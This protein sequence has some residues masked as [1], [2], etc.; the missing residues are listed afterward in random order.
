M[1]SIII[2]AHNEATVISR[3]LEALLK[4]AAPEDEIIVC[5]NGCTDQTAEIISG[6]QPRVT[7]VCTSVP[8][9]VQA[10]NL[11]DGVAHSFPRI[12][13]DAD[14]VFQEGCL[15][16]LKQVLHSQNFLAVAPTPQMDMSDSS[17]AVRA[18]YRI[19]LS[20]PYC[21][22]GMIGAGVYG[23]SARGR[24]RFDRFPD[25]IADDGYVRALF[26]EHERCKV[27]GARVTVR[28]PAT[29]SSLL[30]IKIRSRT[31]QMQLASAYPDLLANERK[32][33]I[34]GLGKVMRNPARWPAAL[35]YLWISVATR[36]AAKNQLGRAATLTWEKDWS[37][38]R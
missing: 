2:P 34:G 12:Y 4:Q 11:G 30:R 6:Y 32:A 16:R 24:A 8:S 28:A 26:Q 29:L 15:D 27:D 10:L 33:Y 20:L 21:Q 5:A 22:R 25:L 3:S 37:S 36:V 17:W 38:R 1:A 14:V 31:G 19:W 9:K 23:L 35:V 18:Y 13:A 7:L